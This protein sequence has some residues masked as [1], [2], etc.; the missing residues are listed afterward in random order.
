V[1]GKLWAVMR[2][3]ITG[4]SSLRPMMDR[5]RHDDRLG[6]SSPRSLGPVSLAVCAHD[7]DCAG[8]LNSTRDRLSCSNLKPLS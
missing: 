4:P 1:D 5:I 8:K 6:R 3:F 7:V 2:G